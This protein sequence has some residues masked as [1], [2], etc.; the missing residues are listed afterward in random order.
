[1]PSRPDL[2]RPAY[3][4]PCAEAPAGPGTGVSPAGLVLASTERSS[5]LDMFPSITS[6]R[7]RASSRPIKWKATSLW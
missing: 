3:H 1:M 6:P 2:S 4:P 5:I 7:L